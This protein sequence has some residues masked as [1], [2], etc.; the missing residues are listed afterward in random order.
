MQTEPPKTYGEE[1]WAMIRVAALYITCVLAAMVFLATI[2]ASIV[3]VAT[4][5]EWYLKL[6]AALQV[7]FGNPKPLLWLA[8]LIAVGGAWGYVY[9][10]PILGVLAGV[11]AFFLAIITVVTIV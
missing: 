5:D 8:A 7:F 9:R 3:M 2:T 4:V 10:R 1:G 11:A 6:Y